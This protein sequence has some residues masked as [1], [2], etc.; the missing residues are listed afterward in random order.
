MTTLE[1]LGKI[2]VFDSDV[3]T[4]LYRPWKSTPAVAPSCRWWKG[5]ISLS[6]LSCS[7]AWSME[8]AEAL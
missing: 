6:R 4:W 1:F 8:G 2:Q 7:V 5:G 3:M